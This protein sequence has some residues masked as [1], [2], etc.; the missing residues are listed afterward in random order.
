MHRRLALLALSTL[1]LAACS[2][3]DAAAPPP[4]TVPLVGELPSPLATDADA[5]TAATA[6]T[7]ETTP[8]PGLFGA[9][10][11]DV[12]GRP[13]TAVA[14]T[15]LDPLAPIGEQVHGNRLL[16]IG[17]SVLA[18]LSSRYSDRLCSYLVWR[19]WA[20]E[21]DAEVGRR[22]EFGRQVLAARGSAGWDAAVVMLGNNYDDD[23]QAFGTELEALLDELGDVPVVLL[24]TSHFRSSQDEVNYVLLTTAA[25]R[26]NVRIVD[27]QARTAEPDGDDLLS[28]D[29]LHLSDKGQM[30]LSAMIA[31][32]L[33]MAPSGHE[34][35]CLPSQFTDDSAGPSIGHRR[36]TGSSSGSSESG[37]RP[38][39]S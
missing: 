24:T 22:I 29:E 23:P 27:W 9:A 11:S 7:T 36:H 35:A 39:G 26:P 21:I 2:S 4:G 3:S 6:T 1:V 14:V 33:G 13:T 5:T 38:G 16:V 30:A 34:G 8:G 17:D 15:A 31:G 28:G 25:E 12:F 18:S 10:E 19:R 32:A 20:V 37:A